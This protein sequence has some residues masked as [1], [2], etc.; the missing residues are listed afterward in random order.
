MKE[1]KRQSEMLAAVGCGRRAGGVPA[2]RDGR[3]NGF[4]LKTKTMTERKG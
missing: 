3:R 4:N 2:A 1:T